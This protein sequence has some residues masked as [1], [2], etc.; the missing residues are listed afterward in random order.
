MTETYGC[1]ARRLFVLRCVAHRFVFDEDEK[2][3]FAN[4][5]S[6]QTCRRGI[7]KLIYSE[8]LQRRLYQLTCRTEGISGDD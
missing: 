1:E 8:E 2:M 5:E 7:F 6:M 4:V 3:V